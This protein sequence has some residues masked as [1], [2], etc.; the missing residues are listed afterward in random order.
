[1]EELHQGTSLR[2]PKTLGQRGYGVVEERVRAR[3]ERISKGSE[4]RKKQGTSHILG[5]N[6]SQPR[7]ALCWPHGRADVSPIG[8]NRQRPST[9]HASSRETGCSFSNR[10]SRA[11]GSLGSRGR[12]STRSQGR[13]R[14]CSQLRPSYAQG[15]SS[16][17]RSGQGGAPGEG[18]IE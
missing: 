13:S 3:R 17:G 2:I 15:Q 4:V 6:D 11:G 12:G 16:L 7:P 8:T 10:A 18:E 1:M 5:R 14:P 9:S